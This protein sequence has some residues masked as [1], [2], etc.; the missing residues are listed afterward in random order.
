M[1][2]VSRHLILTF[3]GTRD[4]KAVLHDPFYVSCKTPF[5]SLIK[6]LLRLGVQPVPEKMRLEMVI[7]MQTKIL[8]GHSRSLFEG[9]I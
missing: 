5:T 1:S 2:Q 9:L 4:V 7:G 3:V 6:L 8:D